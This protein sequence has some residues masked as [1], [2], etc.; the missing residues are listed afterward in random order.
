MSTFTFEGAVNSKMYVSIAVKCDAHA[1]AIVENE[2]SSQKKRAANGNIS[3]F[4]EG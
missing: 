4:H 3:E 2:G 1:A